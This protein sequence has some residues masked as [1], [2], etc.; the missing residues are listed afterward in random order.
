M[1]HRSEPAPLRSHVQQGTKNCFQTFVFQTW[2]G[3]VVLF[4]TFPFQCFIIFVPKLSSDPFDFR[5]ESWIWD[6]LNKYYYFDCKYVKQLQLLWHSLATLKPH[7]SLTQRGRFKLIYSISQDEYKWIKI[8]FYWNTPQPL[9]KKTS[10]LSFEAGKT[11]AAATS[12]P[13]LNHT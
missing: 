9:R 1:Q 12:Q 2:V 5:M 13:F 4:T 7:G 11:D 3:H 10:V 6:S 8:K